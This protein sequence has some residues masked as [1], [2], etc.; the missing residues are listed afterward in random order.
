MA[1][2]SATPAIE[3]PRPPDSP[4]ASGEPELDPQSRGPGTVEAPSPILAPVSIGAPPPPAVTPEAGIILVRLARAVVAATV[5]RRDPLPDLEAALPPNLP[6]ALAVHAAAFVTLHRGGELRGCVGSLADDRPL[7]LN[8][9]SA[10]ASAARDPRLPVLRPREVPELTVDVSVLGPVVVLED[11]CAFR[12]GVD[13]L[14]VAR[15][16]RRGLLLPEV[17]TEHDWGVLA[18]LQATCWKAGLGEDAWRDPGTTVSAFAT[19]RIRDEAP[20]GG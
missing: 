15:G 14:I 12:P 6:A 8:V 18:M 2:A 4:T 10:A 1:T 20:I 7:W 16:P 17:A 19:T 5:A 3:N 11:P 13:G 9:A